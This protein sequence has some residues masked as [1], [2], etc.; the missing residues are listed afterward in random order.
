APESIDAPFQQRVQRAFDMAQS[1]RNLGDTVLNYLTIPAVIMS[2]LFSVIIVFS[3][4]LFMRGHDLPGGGF[5]GGVTLAIGFILQYL[6]R[7]IRWVEN[8]LRVLP[9]R[10][11]GFGLL[12]SV[13]TGMG[14][15]FVGYPFL[16]SF[17]QY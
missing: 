12:L 1:D 7:D 10:W 16:T 11:L 3:I 6:A 8:H 9:L 14:A 2:W 4:Y 13:A 5:V 15:W 17:F